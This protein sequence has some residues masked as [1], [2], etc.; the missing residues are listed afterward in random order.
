MAIL[1]STGVRLPHYF[2]QTTAQIMNSE[3]PDLRTDKIEYKIHG[4]RTQNGA[5]V[6]VYSRVYRDLIRIQSLYGSTIYMNA[7]S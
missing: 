6:W 1:A 5:L 3:N 2:T 7:M 4:A